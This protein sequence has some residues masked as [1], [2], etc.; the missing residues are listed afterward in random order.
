L[1]EKPA[2]VLGSSSCENKSQSLPLHVPCSS[3]SPWHLSPSWIKSTVGPQFSPFPNFRLRQKLCTCVYT[4]RE[5]ETDRAGTEKEKERR[6]GR[7]RQSLKGREPTDVVY[8][9]I[10]NHAQIP[11][12]LSYF[13]V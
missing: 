8:I 13:T 5:T 4:E 3:F 10:K 2:P 12:C 6:T 7:E 11:V 1:L 9:S